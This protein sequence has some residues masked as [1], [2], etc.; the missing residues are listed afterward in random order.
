MNQIL[1]KLNNKTAKVAIVGGG[2]VGL[3]LAVE[4]AKAGFTVTVFELDE[5]KINELTNGRSYI[6]DVKTD[7]IAA[8]VS[9]GRLSATSDMSRLAVMDAVTICVPTPLNKTRDPDLTFIVA[10]T[11]TLAKYMHPGMLVTLE[12]TTF[13]GTT[14]ELVLPMLTGD[15][16]F[17]VG[18]EFFLC[19]S[20][21]RIDPGNKN[22]N[23]RNIPKIVGGVT[24]ECAV[25]GE[26]FYSHAVDTIVKVKNT[27][28]AEM[29]KLLE[30]TFRLINIAFVNELA[31][32]CNQM[33]IDVWSVI[34]AAST[35]PFGFM[36]FWPGSGVGG[37]C[38]P[39][40]FKY[41]TWKSK[42][43]G[44]DPRFIEL[45][46]VINGQMPHYV[47]QKV[48]DALNVQGKA[49][50]GSSILL[51]GMAY[52]KDIDDVRE[53]PALDVAHLLIDKGSLLTYYDPYIPTAKVNGYS[54]ESAK[55]SDLDNEL[56]MADCVVVTTDHTVIDYAKVLGLSRLVV[57]TRNALHGLTSPK[58]VRL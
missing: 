22:F 55:E 39:C 1:E 48:Q 4:Y 21:E 8:L 47:V 45:A 52:K 23:T 51:L 6:P 25:V 40:D 34:E 30:N 24:P 2:Y 50:K 44:C 43:Y 10:A 5:F 46:G 12:S 38:L 11:E 27:V 3:P 36:T 57:G 53:S 54:L 7:E 58:I 31:I 17:V 32:M 35:K 18:S 15:K 16:P 29:V 49:L 14:E 13:P 20:P 42:Q 37:H 41:L 26:A 33:G 19:F 56:R 9:S 28:T